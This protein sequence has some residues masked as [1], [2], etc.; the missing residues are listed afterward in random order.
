MARRSRSR[1]LARDSVSR[2]SAAKRSPIP[3]HHQPVRHHHGPLAGHPGAGD[4]RSGTNDLT[5]TVYGFSVTILQRQGLRRRPRPA[6]CQSAG[7]RRHWRSEW[8]ATNSTISSPTIRARA[9]YDPQRAAGVRR[10][11]L[12]LSNQ[13]DADQLF[14]TCRLSARPRRPRQRPRVVLGLEESVHA[15]ERHRAPLTSRLP[16]AQGG[17]RGQHVGQGAQLDGAPGDQ[18]RLQPLRLEEPAGGGAARQFSELVFPGGVNVGQR[19]NYP[20]EFYQN[21]YSIRYDLSL[22]RGSHD[23]KVG[24]E[25]LRWHDTGQWQLLSRGEF[26]FSIHPA[27]PGTRVPAAPRTTHALGPLRPRQRGCCATT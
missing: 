2:N 17:Q 13:A 16:N 27:G 23:L 15:G 9:Q 12:L 8:C 1:W 3:G 11:E 25:Y 4:L 20:Q 22:H 19:R 26:I 14:G 21:T 10:P 5:G 18:V 6:V 7:G 24:G